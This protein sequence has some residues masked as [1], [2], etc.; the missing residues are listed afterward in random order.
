MCRS[1]KTLHNFKPPATEEEI[2][3][4]ALQFVRKLSGFARPSHANELAFNG[5]VDQVAH[6]AHEL[7]DLLVTNAPPPDRETEAA[8]ARPGGRAIPFLGA[9]RGRADRRRAGFARNAAADRHSIRKPGV[10]ACGVDNQTIR[11]YGGSAPFSNL[12]M[13][14]VA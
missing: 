12:A 4:S 8:K 5:A 2:R 3:A 11:G 14:R 9:Q 10:R 7:L 13:T 1:I 6:A